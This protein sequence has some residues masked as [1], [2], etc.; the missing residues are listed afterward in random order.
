M[1]SL[2][3][4]SAIPLISSFVLLVAVTLKLLGLN[5]AIVGI[6]GLTAMIALLISS[7]KVVFLNNNHFNE[8]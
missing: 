8:D 7:F 5:S 3:R 1:K 4:N 2:L 6:L